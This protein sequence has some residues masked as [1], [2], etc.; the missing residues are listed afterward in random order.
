[1][2]YYPQGKVIR[3]F[4]LSNP[5]ICP[6][7]SLLGGGGGGGGPNI[8]VWSSLLSHYVTMY[9]YAVDYAIGT[10]NTHART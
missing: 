8:D 1:M 9:T 2:I 3:H 4:P 10:Y 5:H 6:T 7:N